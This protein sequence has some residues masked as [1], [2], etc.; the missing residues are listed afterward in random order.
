MIRSLAATARVMLEAVSELR[1][2]R[3]WLPAAPAIGT[4][5]STDLIAALPKPKARAGKVDDEPPF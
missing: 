2:P 5:T 3:V 1:Q 4:V